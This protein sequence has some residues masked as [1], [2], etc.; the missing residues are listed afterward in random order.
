[1]RASYTRRMGITLTRPPLFRFMAWLEHRRTLCEYC[2]K[3]PKDLALDGYCSEFC[4]EAHYE[5]QA[6][7]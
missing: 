4:A 5:N 2:R 7:G 1:M 3:A 6:H